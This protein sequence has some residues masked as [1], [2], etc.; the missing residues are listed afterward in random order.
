MRIGIVGAGAIGSLLGARLAVSGS[1]V[2]FIDLPPRLAALRKD[3]VRIV[4]TDGST[5]RLASPQLAEC[6]QE[7]IALDAVILAVKAHDVAACLPALKVLLGE[8]TA[9]ITIQNG[10]PWWYFERHAGPLAGT[11][12]SSLDPDGSIAAAIDAR[13]IIGCVAYPAAALASDG[14]VE[15]VEGQRFPLGEIDG[16]TTPRVQAFAAAFT[17]A[18]FKSPVLEDIRAETWLKAWGN[19]SFN[20]VSALTGA[21]MGEICQQ[22]ET[23]GLVVAMMREA[24]VIAEALGINFRVSLERRLAGA[25]QLGKH[26]T[27]MLQDLESGRRLELDAL[28]GAVLEIGSLVGRDAPSIRL[29]YALT[30]L[31]DVNRRAAARAD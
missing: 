27:S 1:D 4:A 15:H 16:A 31:L 6:G 18:G 19:L 20:P 8:Q 13:R 25:A 24:Q 28:V 11:R 10:I 30:K 7:V 22:P 9:V 14:T 17:A 5:V 2:T 12:L 26:R 23:R 21:T 3:G 29:V